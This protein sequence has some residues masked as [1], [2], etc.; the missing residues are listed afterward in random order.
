M[1]NAIGFD[2]QFHLHSDRIGAGLLVVNDQSGDARLQVNKFFLSGA[3]MRSFN[4]HNVSA[5]LQG[6]LVLKTF[7]IDALTFPEQ[8]DMST[9]YFNSQLA[10][11]EAS[12]NNQLS[13]IDINVGATWDKK[14]GKIH[15]E[16]GFALFHIT[17][18]N[19]SF[20]GIDEDLT[21]RQVIFGGARFDLNDKFYLRPNLLV[22]TTTQATDFIMGSNGGLKFAE[23]GLNAKSFYIGIQFRDG[24]QRNTDAAVAIT[25]ME[26]KHLDIGFSYDINISEL[27][28]ATNNRG[29][30]EVSII[31]T[32]LST[33]LT[34]SAIPCD[35]Y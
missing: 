31:Y 10:S 22:M 4:G 18:P 15:P 21:V 25:G 9:G 26:F 11:G 2:K 13:Y 14:F 7:S 27:D 12:V 20:F 24:W 3:Y 8:F 35:R 29:A 16:A 17:T 5:G 23:N 34:K 32:A 1:T 19:E 30:F 28:V 6:G 33:V